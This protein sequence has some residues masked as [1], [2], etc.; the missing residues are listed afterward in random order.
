MLPARHKS[1]EPVKAGQEGT[2]DPSPGPASVSIMVRATEPMADAPSRVSPP[3]RK[4]ARW[5]KDL[6][7]A[8]SLLR[9]ENRGC[10]DYSE[11]QPSG[12]PARPE[13]QIPHGGRVAPTMDE[14]ALTEPENPAP[15]SHHGGD[16]T[17]EATD[18][19]ENGGR[20]L[21]SS[22]N[23]GKPSTWRRKA[24]DHRVQAGGGLMPS[25]VNTGFV[26]DMQRKLYRWRFDHPWQSPRIESRMQGN[27]H[28]RF[29]EGDEET[30]PSNDRWRGRVRD[31]AT[32]IVRRR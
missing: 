30:C 3:I 32:A 12:K 15:A 18:D 9:G 13:G 14:R 24:V 29:G 21:R 28:V 20:S 8:G 16:G 1:A 22:P 27:L 6:W 17:I 7:S 19:R 2:S 23:T 4:W 10:P 26:L 11:H 25:A 5:S 31:R